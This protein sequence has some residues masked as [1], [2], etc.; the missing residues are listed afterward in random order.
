M[1]KKR[2]YNL[3]LGLVAL[4]VIVLLIALIGYL[5]SKPK[6]M[7]IQGE[8][9][10]SEY[11][12]SGMVPGRIT[13]LYVREGQEVK[14]GDTLVYVNSPQVQA[15][16]S[17]ATAARSAASAQSLKARNGAT[18]EQIT[19][20]YELWQQAKVQ[21]DVMRKSFERVQN[22]YDQKVISAQKYD[23]T[24]AKYDAAVAQ[25]KAAKSQYDAALKGARS[26]DKAA[27]AALVAQANG[28]VQEVN[29]YL[30]ELYLTAPVD[31]IITNVYPN[32]GELVGTGSPIMTVT[33]LSDLW[34]TFNIREDYLH[35]LNI[36][37]E[38]TVSIPALDGKQIRTK[39]NYI[40]VRESYATWKATKESDMFDAKTFEVRTVPVDGAEGVLP[41]MTALV[42]KEK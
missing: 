10:A 20:A 1:A 24:K 5:V 12:I 11:R 18:D 19:G 26:E 33:D 36:G 28:A 22:L 21:E 6:P 29:S 40:A 15:K 31:G 27:A 3:I 16:L 42:V 17:Q 9:N 35:G 13:T 4:I 41:G 2:N 32:V 38:V 30:N 8:A 14:S 34:F 37:D 23:E 7:V 25:A 39:V